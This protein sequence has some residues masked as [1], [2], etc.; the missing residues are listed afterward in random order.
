MQKAVQFIGL[1]LFPLH[2]WAGEPP[3]GPPAEEKK[4]P[5][6]HLYLDWNPEE[7]HYSGPS[8]A[9]GQLSPVALMRA[10]CDFHSPVPGAVTSG[11]G[12]R[13]RRMH[14]GIDLDLNTGDTVVAAFEGMVRY[15]GYNSSYGN[16]VVLRHSNGLET[17]YAHL[18]YLGVKP[19]DYLQAGT[20]LG[21][22]GNTGRSF[23]SHLHFEV[24]YLG[25]PMDPSLVIDF[26]SGQVRF[27]VAELYRKNQVL[28]V[29]NGEKFYRVMPGDDLIRLARQFGMDA[30]ALADLNELD[31]GDLLPIDME[32][33]YR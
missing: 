28:K 30:Q 33:R 6:S 32:L 9:E 13:W 21:L 17:Y 16:L 18:D 31:P 20:W 24:R 2:M 19:G 26:E 15:A 25:L 27:E 5:A 14:Y 8:L 3:A 1:L 11:F 23:G 10:S 12:R 7:I 22:G 29:K 4:V